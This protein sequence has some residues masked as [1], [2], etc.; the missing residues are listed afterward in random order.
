MNSLARDFVSVE[1]RL[2][3]FKLGHH[4]ASSLAGFIAGAT[5]ATIIWYIATKT[6]ESLTVS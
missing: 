3:S 1:K 6:L 2:F 4:V 5:V